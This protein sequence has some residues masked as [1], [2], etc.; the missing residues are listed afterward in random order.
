MDGCDGDAW[1]PNLAVTGTNGAKRGEEE[2]AM[3]GC[4]GDGRGQV[5]SMKSSGLASRVISSQWERSKRE[6]RARR[7][8]AMWVGPNWEGVPPPK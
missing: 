3:D 6:E 8:V 2:A 7:R 4:D 5:P 1:Q